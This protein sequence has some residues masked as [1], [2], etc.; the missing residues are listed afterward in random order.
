MLKSENY[1]PCGFF[2]LSCAGS[3]SPASF[4]L[5]LSSHP[6]KSTREAR[7]KIHTTGPADMA[8]KDNLLTICGIVATVS[9]AVMVVTGLLTTDV[10]GEV[11]QLPTKIKKSYKQYDD[12]KVHYASFFFKSFRSSSDP[13]K[14][15]QNSRYY[16][17]NEEKNW[18]DAEEFCTSRGAHLASILNDEE[19][20]FISSQLQRTSWI[21]L[22][23]EN[24]ESEWRWA[25]GSSLVEEFWSEDQPSITRFLR[26]SYEDCATIV[27]SLAYRNWKND[28]CRNRYRW[29]C[30][31]DLGDAEQKSQQNQSSEGY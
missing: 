15:H 2:P 4:P 8:L 6:R 19:Q 29:V 27:P 17:S 22:A 26:S 28:N 14:S 5:C 24:E 13:W 30:K 16:F 3:P 10:A 31:D 12:T 23:F 11:R 9:L 1:R 7:G 25:D 20:N 18:Y 21:G